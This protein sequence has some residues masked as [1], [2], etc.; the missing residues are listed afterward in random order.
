MNY[1]YSF[2]E[3]LKTKSTKSY[4][5]EHCENGKSGD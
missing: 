3:N 2:V 1:L 4:T 5:Y